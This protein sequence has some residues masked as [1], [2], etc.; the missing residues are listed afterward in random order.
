MSD[1]EEPGEP[2]LPQPARFWTVEEANARLVELKESMPQLRARVVRLR[3][4]FD[5]LHRLSGFWGKE[6]DAVDNPDRALKGRLDSEW[7]ALTKQVEDEV[8]QLQAEGIEVK[9][10]ESGLVDFYGLQ[11]GE[12]VFLCW[13]RGEDEVGF[14]HSLE[15]GFRNRRPLPDRSRATTAHSPGPP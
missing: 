6:V 12:V 2:P 13:Q 11:E 10:L 3:K 9:D 4:V 7:A 1:R 14:Y 5:E 15:G 8:S